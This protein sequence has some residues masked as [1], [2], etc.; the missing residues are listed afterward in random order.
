MEAALALGLSQVS[1]LMVDDDPTMRAAVRSTL[2][3][4][5]NRELVQMAEAAEA[6]DYLRHRQVDLVLSDCRMAPM[7]G[8][9]FLR[10][11]REHPRTEHLPVIMLTASSDGRDAWEARELHATAWLVKP[12]LPQVLLGQIA[13]ALGMA[14]PPVATDVLARLAARYEAELP[15]EIAMLEAMVARLPAQPG[16]QDPLA[17][18]MLGRLHQTQGQAGTLGYPLISVLAGALHDTLRTWLRHPQAHGAEV[19]RLLTVGASAMKLVAARR[20]RGE[21]GAAG[22]SI[23]QHVAHFAG[24]LQRRI[25]AEAREAEAEVRRLR[26]LAA[27]RAAEADA[28]RWRLQREIQQQTR[29]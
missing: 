21:G 24:N 18:E 25:E 26:D 5:G 19:R 28:D 1:I 10:R 12:V 14:P 6:L 9:T 29:R 16:P 7:D 17:E 4:A 20:L 3:A 13:A 22:D 11:L 23:R 8:I 2:R 27:V 15:S